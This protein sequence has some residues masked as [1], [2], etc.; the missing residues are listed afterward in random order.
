VLVAK[1]GPGFYSACDDLAALL[2]ETGQASERRDVGGHP[3][4]VGWRE[5]KHIRRRL[6]EPDQNKVA[7]QDDNGKIKGIK[8]ID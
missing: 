7:S 2:F 8:D 1:I 4:D 6:I 5:A 3:T